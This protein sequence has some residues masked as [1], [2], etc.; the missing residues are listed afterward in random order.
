MLIFVVRPSH[1]GEFKVENQS[2]PN[3]SFS[4]PSFKHHHVLPGAYS[5]CANTT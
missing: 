2:F 3:E 5:S 4:G 1:Y